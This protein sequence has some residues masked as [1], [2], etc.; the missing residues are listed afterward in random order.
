MR[1]VLITSAL[2]TIL[3]LAGCNEA[4]AP[5]EQATA[6]PEPT[7]SDARKAEINAL[8]HD[9]LIALVRSSSGAEFTYADERLAGILE[10]TTDSELIEKV[11]SPRLPFGDAM[12]QANMAKTRLANKPG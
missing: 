6:T 2:C 8:S 10:S 5:V 9:E 12:Y 7:I 4:P 1:T 3:L 11:T